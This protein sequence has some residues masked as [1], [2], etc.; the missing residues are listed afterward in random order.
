MK[1]EEIDQYASGMAKQ[2]AKDTLRKA[3]PEVL[4]MAIG[5]AGWY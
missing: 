3:D 2:Q 1:Q 5:N 4:A